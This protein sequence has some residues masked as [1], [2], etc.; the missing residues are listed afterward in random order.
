M[1]TP[2]RLL[3][4]G[5]ETALRELHDRLYNE[6]LQATFC[7]DGGS[8]LRAIRQSGM[9]HLLITD[10]DLP[11]MDSL[12]L[13]RELQGLADLPIII[14]SGREEPGL[15]AKALQVAD[16]YVRKPVEPDE[17][18]MRIRRIL[19][20]IG[21]FSY[22]AGPLIEICDHLTIDQ[23]HRRVV[24]D[25]KPR[26]LTPTEGTLLQVLIKHQGTVIEPDVLIERVWRA[27]FNIQDR[28][29]LRVHIHRLRHKLEREPG[30]PSIIVTE[31]GQGYVFVG[32]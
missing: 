31:R 11:D 7:P 19:S 8:A 23:F 25:G 1:E 9:P 12:A 5:E 6:G 2:R 4:V 14:L 20:R 21:N 27:G 29:A 17:L 18:A 26:Q 24:V 32:C 15:A 30:S 28:N 13:C 22:A 3:V 10:L 16:D